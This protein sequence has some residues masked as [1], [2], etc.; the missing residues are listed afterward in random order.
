MSRATATEAKMRPMVNST[1]AS[2]PA[3]YRRE[4]SSLSKKTLPIATR[5]N[6]TNSANGK[7]T[8]KRVMAV[9]STKP[10]AIANTP[11]ARLTKPIRPIVTDR[12]TEMTYRIMP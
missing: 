6:A 7:G 1:C 9:D 8:P 10:P 5:R 2:S 4:Y 12:P 11:C 3:A